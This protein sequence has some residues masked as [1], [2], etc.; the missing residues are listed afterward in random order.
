M[1]LELAV[2]DALNRFNETRIMPGWVTDDGRKMAPG[3][4]FIDSNYQTN[5]VYSFV[6]RAN[7]IARRFLPSS[8]YG[9]GQQPGFRKYSHPDKQ[10][11]G[12]KHIGDGY[13]VRYSEKRQQYGARVDADYW[14]TWIR[15]RLLTEPPGSPGSL[16][17]YQA[18]SG[19]HRNFCAHLDSEDEQQEI[20]VGKGIVT[21]WY[22]KTGRQ[23]H[24]L[25]SS[26]LACAAG[27]LCGVRLV[28]PMSETIVPRTA[29]RR[30]VVTMPDG[31]PY[32]VTER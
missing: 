19:E 14:K 20:V 24:Y 30:P 13:H 6:E 11:S 25:D 8:G 9:G 10:S 17:F 27:H 31:R 12:V 15:Q 26:Y 21:R 2:I 7:T 18:L 16:V 3:W 23:N 32:L 29:E 28:V 1:P 22:N 4:V 5:A